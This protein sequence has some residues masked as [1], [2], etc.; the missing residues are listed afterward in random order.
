MES[1][2]HQNL[3]HMSKSHGLY[4]D[5]TNLL[6]DVGTLLSYF[7]TVIAGCHECL[8]CGT[9]RSTLQAV[10]QHMMAKGHC[11]Y[12]TADEVVRDFYD[13]PPS[14][15]MEELRTRFSDDPQLIPHARSRKAR[16]PKHSARQDTNT[17]A[18]L[19]SQVDQRPRPSSQHDTELRSDANEQPSRSLSE[20]ST[21]ALKQEHT[22]NHQLTQLRASDRRSLAHLPA[23]QKRAILATH[24]QQ[25]EK[26]R[27]TE[28][29]QRGN[30]ESAGNHFSRLGTIR[31]IRKPPHTGNVHSLN[32]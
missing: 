11:K 15:A 10:Q 22:L 32:R 6:V 5:L 13:S 19:V 12:D 25:M 30:L 7:H 9:Q 20:L 8:Y 18:A 17:T 27:R 3:A 21:R 14:T 16:P 2:L 23:S 28:Q 31:L 26:A 24:H 1:D 4:V 29:A